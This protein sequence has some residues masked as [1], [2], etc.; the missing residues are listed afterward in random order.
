MGAAE[1][2]DEPTKWRS[3]LWADPVVAQFRSILLE[4]PEAVEKLDLL[5]AW[6]RNADEP[7]TSCDKNMG[8]AC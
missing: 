1:V 4:S 2:A 5:C 8:Q 6:T 3:K 7:D